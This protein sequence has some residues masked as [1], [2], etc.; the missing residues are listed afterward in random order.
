[1]EVFRNMINDELDKIVEKF[2]IGKMD[3][4]R[5]LAAVLDRVMAWEGDKMGKGW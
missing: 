4:A 3:T 2:P 5:A 1:M